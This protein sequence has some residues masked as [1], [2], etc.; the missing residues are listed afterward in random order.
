LTRSCS[1]T[2][3]SRYLDADDRT[4]GHT[5]GSQPIESGSPKHRDVVGGNMK[6]ALA[7][8]VIFGFMLVDFLFFHDIFK[9]GEVVT[10]PQYLTGLLSIPVM[11]V[12]IQVPVRGGG[13][14]R[15]S[16]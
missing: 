9:T 5:Q 2:E 8:A 1:D 10:F 11:V 14:T 13:E 3:I 6:R 12:C 16:R 4:G 15:N 7:I